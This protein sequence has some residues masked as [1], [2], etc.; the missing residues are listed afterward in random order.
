MIGLSNLISQYV[1]DFGI[2]INGGLPLTILGLADGEAD[3]LILGE[4][5]GDADELTDGE[6][7]EDIL[8]DTEELTDGDTLGLIDGE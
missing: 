5:L 6:T 7:D 3:G 4:L 8:G 2:L 1:F